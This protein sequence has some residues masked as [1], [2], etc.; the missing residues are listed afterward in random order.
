MGRHYCVVKVMMI[1]AGLSSEHGK[2]HGIEVDLTSGEF[3]M[4]KL[5][6]ISAPSL[7]TLLQSEP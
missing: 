4:I 1:S 2:H 3:I 6:G 5:G 7:D